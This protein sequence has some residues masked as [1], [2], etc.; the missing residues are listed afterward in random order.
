MMVRGPACPGRPSPA[1]SGR[2]TT[3]SG[4]ANAA[5]SVAFGPGGKFLAAGS[6]DTKMRQWSLADSACLLS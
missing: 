4:P 3:L 6:W 2:L 1:R 5:R